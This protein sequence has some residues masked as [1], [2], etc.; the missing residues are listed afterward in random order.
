M[1]DHKLLSAVTGKPSGVLHLDEEAQSV[2]SPITGKKQYIVDPDNP[3]SAG[4]ADVSGVTAEAGDVAA[5]KKFVAADGTLTDGN[6]AAVTQPAPT[7]SI[8]GST[9]VVTASYTPVA[10]Q[11]KDTTAKSATLAL[12]AQAAQTITPGTSDQT[13]PAEKFLTGAQTVKGDANL[14]AGNLKSGVTVFGTTGTFT[15]D[16]DATAGD[17]AAGKTAYV[18]GT[19]ITGT[20][21]AGGGG[22][23]TVLLMH[24]NDNLNMEGALA[25][26]GIVAH[27]INHEDL[28]MG[29]NPTS[30]T[31]TFG[32]GKFGNAIFFD[33]SQQGEEEWDPYYNHRLI[34]P[35]GGEFLTDDFTIE[36]WYKAL[37]GW[38][39]AG[40][41]IKN[42]NANLFRCE[43]AGGPSAGSPSDYQGLRF[44]LGDG[45][46]RVILDYVNAQLAVN[47]WHHL[48][49]VRYSGNFNV[50][51]DGTSIY[52]P[53]SVSSFTAITKNGMLTLGA[54]DSR[55]HA[56]I[57]EL[58]I[59]KVARYTAAFTPPAA[60]FTVD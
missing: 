28:W 40:G 37:D 47:T 51:A 4:G 1:S 41:L 32:T 34:L 9:G 2:R 56:Y 25:D 43:L 59:S 21:S 20:A 31:P 22:G 14:V 6:L 55:L 29:D 60:A 3:I 23:N 17:I 5:D 45:T 26:G 49:F 19:K 48:A 16:A 10:G 54:I 53:T 30:W 38:D 8:D 7:L 44:E 13:I 15:S 11:V 12:T 39:N 57:D 36:F 35:V 46:N 24:F 58:R 50:Y 33:G 18:N 52:G 42:F 27:Q